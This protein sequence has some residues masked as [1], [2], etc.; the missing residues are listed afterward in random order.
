VRGTCN[1][2]QQC[3]PDGSGFTPCECSTTTGVIDAG[4]AS[5][6]DSGAHDAGH[7]RCD[8]GIDDDGDGKIDCADDDCAAMRCSPA[9]PS[10]W[11]G[12]V[13]FR[14]SDDEA[15]CAG[16]FERV[17]WRGGNDPQA[18][19]VSCS[20]CTCDGNSSCASAIDFVS[21]SEAQC[22]GKS[23]STSINQ[24]CAEISP[25]CLADLT[26]AYMKTALASAAGCQPSEQHADKP[27]PS[28]RTHA[29]ACSP[30]ALSTGGCAKDELCAPAADGGDGFEGRYC[31]YRD[32][33]RDCP[34]ATFTDRRVY[35]R[36]FKDTRACSTCSCGGDECQYR[37]RVFNADD[38]SCAT[39][40]LELSSED[41]CVQVNPKD[42]K[43]R[44]G[45]MISGGGACTASGGE[46]S[47]D[48][49]A[50]DAVTLCCSK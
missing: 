50:D 16:A 38:T 1:G 23:C 37:W 8:N 27:A 40:L 48:V 34:S 33:E 36:A 30:G 25:A 18:D 46:S 20:K 12:P 14:E 29:L 9:A 31:V 49:S 15:T 3:K 44:V 2:F 19:A 39:P 42:G 41:Q 32:G 22:G 11:Q 10:G 45:A 26:T 13:V 28:W 17:A 5:D 21:S 6:G 47:G 35:H 24:A 4:D 7:E 43:L